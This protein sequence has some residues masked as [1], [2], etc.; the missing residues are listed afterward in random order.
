MKIIMI[1][2]TTENELLKF[3]ERSFFNPI[4]GFTKNE[5]AMGLIQV[6]NLLIVLELI[7]FI[8]NVIVLLEV[9]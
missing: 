6:E 5:S 4:L 3:N 8:S 1:K 2:N 7:R 9:L